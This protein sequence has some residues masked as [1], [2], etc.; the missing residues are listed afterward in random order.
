M[1]LPQRLV[2]RVFSFVHLLVVLSC[3]ALAARSDAAGAP[4]DLAA[5]GLDVFLH[6]PPSAAPR[7]LLPVQVQAVGFPTAVSSSPLAQVAIEAAWDPEHLGPGVSTA[8]PPVRATTD[9][10]GT[11]HLEVQVP[12]GEEL[13]LSLLVSVRSGA[14]LRTRAV[15]VRRVKPH[16]V[17]LHTSDPHVVPGSTVSAWVLVTSATTGDPVP[18][19]PVVVSLSEGGVERFTTTV[20]T[21]GAGTATAHV[22]IPRTEEPTWSWH[23][24]ART[25][26]KAGFDSGNG[27]VTLSTREETPGSPTL[28]ASWRDD[29]VR[30]GERAKFVVRVRDAAGSPVAGIAVRTWF[31]PKGT[32]VPKEEAAW[33]KLSTLALTSAMGEVEGTADA[34]STVRGAGTTLEL[35]AKAVVDSHALAQHATVLVG[36]T[37]STAELLPERGKII[38]GLEQ[39]MLLRLRDGKGAPIKAAFSV[40]ADGLRERVTTDAHG[41]AEI[42]WHPPVDLGAL[43]HIGPCA[44]GVAAAV[45]VRA[46]GEV[47]QLG[48]RREPFEICVSVD[49]DVSAVVRADAPLARA[50]D[51]VHVRVISP[52]REKIPANRGGGWSLVLQN[53]AGTQAA[54]AWVADG[55]KGTDIELPP[56]ATGVWSL[57]AASPGRTSSTGRVAAGAIL[58]TPRTLPKVSAK[59]VGGRA[60]PGDTIEVEAELTDTAGRP[61]T[62]TVSAVM[63]DLHGGGSLEGLT[64]LDTRRALC[65]QADI[66]TERCDAFVE[67][68]PAL[69]PVRRGLL[70][71]HD[72][73]GLVP[74]SDP[75]G[76]MQEQMRK[77]FRDVVHSL[78]GAVNEATR[79]ADQLKDVRRKGSGGWAFNPEVLSLATAAMDP[80]PETPGGESLTLGDLLAIDRQ[81]S[82][83]NVARRV[84][85]LKLFRVLVAMRDF[86]HERKLD[87]D[88]PALKDPNA[89]L[90]RLVRDG[91]IE[92]STLLDP[93]GGTMTFS[94][95]AAAPAPFLTVARGFE[96]RAPGPDGV[97]GSADDVRD[98]FERVLKSGTPY[99]VA[100]DEDIIVDAKLDMELGDATVAAW[101]TLLEKL[102]GTTLGIQEVSGA[103]GLGLLGSGSGGEGLGSGSG[104]G[105]ISRA[106]PLAIAF[107]SPPVRTDAAGRAR[108]RVPLGDLETTWRIALV[109]SPDHATPAT[110]T[111]DVPIALPLSARVDT[112]ASWIEGDVLET[113]V[114][115]RNRTAANVRA[116]LTLTARGACAISDSRTN[117]RIVDVPAG[118][119][120]TIP[121]RIVAAT[122][123]TA[124]LEVTTRAQGLPDDIARHEW[125]VA[126]AG[127]KIDLAH[128]HWVDG[129]A[130]LT[131]WLR[132]GP[133]RALGAARLVLDRG[134]DV[135]LA[136]ALES[137]DP[138]RSASPAA[139]ADAVEV[140]GRLRTYALARGGESDP[141][142]IR[143]LEIG[144]IA[145]GRLL[146]YRKASEQNVK[147]STVARA[148]SFAPGELGKLLIKLSACPASSDISVDELDPALDGLDAEPSP[149][150]GAVASC[151]DGYVA[152]VMDAVERSHDPGAL[153]RALLSL[154]DRPHRAARANVAAE[155]LQK[156]VALDATGAIAVGSKTA[157]DRSARA[158]I[159]AGL[160]RAAT[161]PGPG[162]ASLP[163]LL[164]WAAVQRDPQGGY[165]SP[166]ATRAVV[167]ALLAAASLTPRAKTTV[168][169]IVDGTRRN[170][171]LGTSG[172][173]LVVLDDRA[174]TLQVEA[175]G[176]IARLERPSLRAWS[177]APT[178]ALPSPV[179]MEVTW[180]TA[181]TSKTGV[182]R[183]VLRHDTTRTA[184]ID[185]RLPLPP[186]VTLAES[187]TNVRQ[188]QG[189]LAIRRLVDPGSLTTLVEI[190]VRFGL[191]GTVTV[192]E[193]SA[194]IAFEDVP[195]A[196]APARPLIVQ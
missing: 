91:K 128:I 106:I 160:I 135:A 68:D 16:A 158:T 20:T 183:V 103:G 69:D 50:G 184:L 56:G 193:A 44:G 191:A 25:V 9:G 99:A 49:R 156:I 188:V 32:E 8:P 152:N 123:G 134:N 66:D 140:A 192:P 42:T 10:A 171:D 172:T 58:V 196:L 120:A 109:A 89:M 124:S 130:D 116:T 170:V 163:R 144:R 23:L 129:A 133:H 173:A 125:F 168:S 104:H 12:D 84:T 180:P 53:T 28:T 117:E 95:V 77:A 87:A 151:W 92:E 122:S 82:F 14:H 67:G 139:M 54:S 30:A 167:R 108:I 148:Q 157:D 164:A 149:I 63:I 136:A 29:A 34:P 177:G 80:K 195:R 162:K 52:G 150:G 169:V 194:R 75:S 61:L 5:R 142:A 11:A 155:K 43:R 72:N 181:H 71:A 105:R 62:G 40:E 88:E 111:I 182:L 21:D 112:G 141:M 60:A 185:A 107:W 73:A 102:T 121:V 51:K 110:T 78:E 113:A 81:V 27:S 166:R 24:A 55:A 115:V 154:A 45:V 17:A 65:A 47:P 118:S 70:G 178:D 38:P 36:A 153:A 132:G 96:L 94:S 35:V 186:G 98:P 175:A 147:W 2:R 15:P 146:A 64:R 100:V 6:L 174:K 90:R 26:G 86:K 76:R 179:H 46:E 127:E 131:P 31:G 143:A 37:A 39:R 187:V 74:A 79:S 119:A 41:E 7:A 48:V 126:P 4:D 19:T 101:T 114:T 190:P 33:E 145:T 1:T 13:D 165:G 3:V 83:D 59:I 138:D 97:L 176:I 57:S 161:M 159:F 189:V 137:L 22:P 93:W 18:E 85:R